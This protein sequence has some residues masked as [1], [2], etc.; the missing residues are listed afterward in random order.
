MQ[1]I[2]FVDGCRELVDVYREL[3][4]GDGLD[5]HFFT[6]RVDALAA[7]EGG[8]IPSLVLMDLF[9][10]GTSL[11]GF[12]DEIRA[13]G[14]KSGIEPHIVILSSVGWGGSFEEVPPPLR[15]F[16]RDKPFSSERLKALVRREIA[17]LR[18]S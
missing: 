18:K 10:L 15:P 11:P 5:M 1:P 7:M 16:C 17:G 8:Q 4:E 6:S 14:A 13:M 12:V 2:F 3:F 9:T